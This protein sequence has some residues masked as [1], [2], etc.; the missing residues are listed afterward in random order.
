M[1]DGRGLA[2]RRE[3]GGAWGEG[4]GW[5]Q[6]GVTVG[7]SGRW[8]SEVWVRFGKGL[9]EGWEGCGVIGMWGCWLWAKIGRNMGIGSGVGQG[10]GEGIR[11]AV[12]SM[13]PLSHS[14]V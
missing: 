4:E 1:G 2:V 10:R 7:R 3:Q 14:H 12:G 8:R 13:G 5:E 6:V 9:A 11:R